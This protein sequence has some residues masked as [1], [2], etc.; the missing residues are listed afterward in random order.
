MT[1]KHLDDYVY[2]PLRTLEYLIN[3][4]VLYVSKS[5]NK[6]YLLIPKLNT[7]TSFIND[8]YKH[9]YDELYD[10]LYYIYEVGVVVNE[11]YFHIAD[12]IF[13]FNTSEYYGR[14][15]YLR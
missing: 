5:Q 2:E 8:Y 4:I 3:V 7:S 11:Q 13:T 9:T 14:S 1:Y 15:W 6:A 12:F 10:R